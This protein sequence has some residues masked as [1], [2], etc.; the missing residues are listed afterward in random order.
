[1]FKRFQRLRISLATKCQIL[2]GASVVLIIA[3]ALAVPWQRMERLT[4]QLNERAAEALAD[5]TLAEHIVN[6]RLIARHRQLYRHQRQPNVFA[7]NVAGGGGKFRDRYDKRRAAGR[8][9]GAD[10]SGDSRHP[11]IRHRRTRPACAPTAA[12]DT[13]ASGASAAPVVNRR[14]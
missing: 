5:N 2:F 6:Q 10:P 4:L 14:Q 12:A 8:C 13:S 9:R 7:D 3:A 11:A 1:M